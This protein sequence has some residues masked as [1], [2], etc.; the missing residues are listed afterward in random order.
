[1]KLVADTHS[2]T[3]AS[4]HA[5]NTIR[6]MAQA[7]ASANLELLAITEH[8]PEVEG[9][10]RTIYFENLGVVPRRMY[11]VEM[12]FG[13]EVNILDNQGRL[14][15]YDGLLERL[16]LNIASIHGPCFYVEPT[17]ENVTQ[18]YLHAME[19]PYIDIIGHPDDARFPL[20]IEAFVKKAKETHT[21]IEVNNASLM[22]GSF[23]IDAHDTMLEILKTCKRYDALVTTSNDAHMDVDVGTF[24]YVKKILKECDFPKELVVTTSAKKLKKHLHKWRQA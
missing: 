2:H 19:N 14:D 24:K 5:Y 3:V 13:A 4:G 18:A 23:R 17:V 20:D 16:D 11:G 8:G 22:P 15:L 1:M 6:E 7:A 10:C 9:T 12:L 21:L